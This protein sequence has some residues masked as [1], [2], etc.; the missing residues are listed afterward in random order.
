MLDG[1][2]IDVRPEETESFEGN[3][4]TESRAT[5][6]AQERLLALELLDESTSGFET[7]SW[8]FRD[9]LMM[10]RAKRIVFWCFHSMSHGNNENFN[11]AV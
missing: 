7:E 11:I 4:T 8:K 1:T 3:T 2:V 6:I 10:M 5:E 9:S